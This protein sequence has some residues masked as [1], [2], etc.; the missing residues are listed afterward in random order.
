MTPD[1]TFDADGYPTEATRDTLEYWDVNDFDG[2]MEYLA[3]AWHWPECV[4]QL[5]G[6]VWRFGTGGWSGNESLIHALREN[7]IWWMKYWESSTR[8]GLH[9]FCRSGDG[10]P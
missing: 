5:P 2:A 8:S 10:K 3:K 9:F 4:T 7:R 1:P 6:N